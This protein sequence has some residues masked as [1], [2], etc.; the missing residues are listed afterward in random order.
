M[1]AHERT[2]RARIAASMIAAADILG[3]E[4]EDAQIVR[5]IARARTAQ[6]KKP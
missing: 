4:L 2:K 3:L 6:G 1:D 5:V